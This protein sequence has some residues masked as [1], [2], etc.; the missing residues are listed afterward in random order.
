M[1][2]VA[3]VRTAPTDEAL[4]EAVRRCVGL[5]GGMGRIV[6]PGQRVLV[7]PN[8][9][10]PLA[11]GVTHFGIL[12]TIIEMVREQG[13][14]PFI[15]DCAGME[16]DSDKTFSLL[17]F[18]DFA[19]EMG[20]DLVNF[21]RDELVCLPVSL[22]PVRRFAMPRSAVEADVVIN[23]PRLKRHSLCRVTL[24]VKNLMG[25]AAKEARRRIHVFGLHKGVALLSTLI[26]SDLTLIDGTTICER[27]VFGIERPLGI[28]LA[29]RDVLAVDRVA[30]RFLDVDSRRVRHLA[31]AERL[32]VGQGAFELVGDA[33]EVPPL[34]GTGGRLR[35]FGRLHRAAFWLTFAAEL[36]YNG[37]TG[38]TLLPFANVTLGSH[39][40]ID[41]DRCD[42]C[43]RCAEACP[44]GAIELD[45]MRI[46][47]R[48]C[49]EV[50]CMRCY[51]VCVKKAIRIKGVQRVQLDSDA[52]EG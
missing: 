2:K 25:V 23:L 19:R 9:V 12:R 33:A 27:P 32:S 48:L 35:L 7:K 50:R 29:S 14:D 16:F 17:G 10:A 37:M 42:R 36:L 3:V 13:G 4:A 49:Q 11:R 22:G 1:A 46:N 5:L 6:R 40:V 18:E 24:G 20:V 15:G 28:L 26:R 21:D 52:N 44:V 39:P 38:R 34:E 51:E 8:V 41:P 31:W 30:C 47:Y 43:G 45:R